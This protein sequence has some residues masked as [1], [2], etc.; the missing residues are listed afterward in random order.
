MNSGAILPLKE[1]IS[2]QKPTVESLKSLKGTSRRGTRPS[3]TAPLAQQM[4]GIHHIEL[5][6][7]DI[8]QLFNTMDP[9]PFHEK[10]L[11]DDAAEFIVSWAQEFHR[12]EPVDL[13]I[14]LQKFPDGQNAQ[15][16]VE[17]AIHNYFAYRAR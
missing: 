10:D 17:D 8:E 13:I 2:A 5:N 3:K 15:P 9:S 12:H 6:L 11:D 14:H 7:Q 4:P 1:P 16:L